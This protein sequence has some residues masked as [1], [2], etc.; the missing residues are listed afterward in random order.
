MKNDGRDRMTNKT[1]DGNHPKTLE[2]LAQTFCKLRCRLCYGACSQC[3]HCYCED[4][5]MDN[6][7][8]YLSDKVK[9]NERIK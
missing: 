6:L 8:E 3:N 1:L 5:I 9:I 7:V 4:C 2:D